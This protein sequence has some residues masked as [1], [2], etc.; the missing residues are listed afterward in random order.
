MNELVG[1]YRPTDARELLAKFAWLPKIYAPGLGGAQPFRDFASDLEAH[2]EATGR[3]LDRL[4]R[5]LANGCVELRLCQ[6]EAEEAR[7]ALRR[8]PVVGGKGGHTR[9][10]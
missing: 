4:Q 10:A 6:A 1:R 7:K 9:A 8:R 2:A 5:E 3:E